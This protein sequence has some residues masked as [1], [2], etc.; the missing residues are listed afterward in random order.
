MGTSTLSGKPEEMLGVTC[1]GLASHPGGVSSRGLGYLA[2]V[3]TERFL[4]IPEYK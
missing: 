4:T 1:D 2:H 3:Q